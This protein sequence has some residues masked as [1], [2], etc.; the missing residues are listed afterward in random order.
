MDS[1]LFKGE[2]KNEVDVTQ[3]NCVIKRSKLLQERLC[4]VQ[5]IRTILNCS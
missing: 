1:S 3:L 2:V 4:N 5:N